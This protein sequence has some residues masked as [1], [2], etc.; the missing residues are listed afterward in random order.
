MTVGRERAK[1]TQYR[2]AAFGAAWEF[3]RLTRSSNWRRALLTPIRQ[4]DVAAAA[5][6]CRKF[7]IEDGASTARAMNASR[8]QRIGSFAGSPA[9]GEAMGRSD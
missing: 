6:I 7:M 2:V 9:T 3:E 8:A 4:R 1:L 5:G